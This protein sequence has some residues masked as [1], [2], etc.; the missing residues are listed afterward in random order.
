MKKISSQSIFSHWLNTQVSGVWINS[1]ESLLDLKLLFFI[2]LAHFSLAVLSSF[3]LSVT[4][5]YV[6]PLFPSTF[7]SSLCHRYFNS[8]CE[9]FSL[10]VRSHL[11][12]FKHISLLFLL[13][14]PIRN[15]NSFQQLDLLDW[16]KSN[17][18]VPSS[19]FNTS[20]RLLIVLTYVLPS[21]FI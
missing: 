2:A 17:T 7:S 21:A 12:H 15:R 20:L 8:L 5:K 10:S 4:K 1:A 16:S 11:N 14:E 6:L 3:S 13:L 9:V 18:F 19:I